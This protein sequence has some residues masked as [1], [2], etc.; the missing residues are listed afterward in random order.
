[1]FPL[2]RKY[3]EA[4]AAAIARSEAERRE[5]DWSEPARV[6]RLPLSY[7]VFPASYSGGPWTGPWV[8]VSSV[9]GRVKS[10]GFAPR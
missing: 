2:V 9:S 10:A 5:W 3:S 4:D 8:V 1:M 6:F 7:R